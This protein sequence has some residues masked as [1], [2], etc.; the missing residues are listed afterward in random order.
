[1]FDW[2]ASPE[3]WVALATLTALE[4]VLGI[5]NIIF[6]SI[7]VGRLPAHQRNFAR[8]TGLALAMLTRLALLF[9]LAWVMGLT[10]P[11]FSVFGT[12]ISGRDIILIGGGL[13]LLAKATHEIHNSME[14]IAEEDKSAIVAPNLI[15]V[16]VQIAILDIVFSLDSVITAVGLADHVSVMAI[17]IVIAVGVMLFAAKPIGDFVDT[18]PTIKILALSFL[19]VVGL[20]LMVEGFDVHVPKGYIYFAMAFSLGVEML[21]IRM[22]KK[23]D[24]VKL[25]KNEP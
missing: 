16:L 20:T 14:G 9:S 23:H 25:H 3:A 1:M 17:A 21:N 18:H 15:M 8:R 5:D 13:F 7:L 2:L 22:R 11:W 10:E 4:I 19:V 12:A 6:I 24:P